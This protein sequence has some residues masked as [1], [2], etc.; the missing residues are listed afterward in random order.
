MKRFFLV[1]ILALFF[2]SVTEAEAP[3]VKRVP[4]WVYLETV[5]GSLTAEEQK[6]QLPPIQELDNMAR[7]I[8]GG[9]IYG[10]KFI[11]T[12]SDLTRK[13]DEYFEISPIKEIEK[14]DP[15]FTIT[16]LT[17]EYPRLL[18]TAIFTLD[19]SLKRW[20][21]YWGSV[22]FKSVNG[23]GYAERTEEVEGI[24]KAYKD[25]VRDAVRTY[26]R[27]LEK[28]KPK[29]IRGE[30]QLRDDPRLFTDGGKYVADIKV[31]IN[32]QD[33]IPYTTF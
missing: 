30:V 11:Y 12:P 17:A 3:R 15:R 26:A 33:L 16:G 7:F 32:M 5:P 13:V 19:D 10:W 18:C 2:F 25:A 6:A 4:V 21:L 8:M 1:V 23:R 24:R 14:D 20:D 29:E 9:M 27:K 28:N 31:F 22:L